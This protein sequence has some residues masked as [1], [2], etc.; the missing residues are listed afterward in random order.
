MKKM[1]YKVLL[2]FQ[3]VI[4][5]ELIHSLL[6][7]NFIMNS[8][9]TNIFEFWMGISLPS[10]LE[11]KVNIEEMEWTPSIEVRFTQSFNA[12]LF[13]A[14]SYVRSHCETPVIRINYAWDF[15]EFFH[16][17]IHESIFHKYNE[18][19]LDGNDENTCE[20]NFVN[21]FGIDVVTISILI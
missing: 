12:F 14:A 5:I 9:K 21:L 2:A 3:M 6:N 16:K 11:S 4:F 15:H 8:M 10:R 7:M 18:K 19:I 20:R 1:A 17:K 13:M